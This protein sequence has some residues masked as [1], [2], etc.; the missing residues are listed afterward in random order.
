MLLLLLRLVL[1]LF[2][3]R[4]LSRSRWLLWL[5]LD[6]DL[7][8]GEWVAEV[9]RLRA[10]PTTLSESIES[11]SSSSK[12]E[13]DLS[14]SSDRRS[15]LSPL[16]ERVRIQEDMKFLCSFC[17]RHFFTVLFIVWCREGGEVLLEL[18]VG[19]AAASISAKRRKKDLRR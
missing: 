9:T 19:P 1:L 2:R 17:S 13:R 7:A 15:P 16:S 8:L 3:W 4:S 5:L 6:L 18:I 14:S 10:P 12:S 11:P